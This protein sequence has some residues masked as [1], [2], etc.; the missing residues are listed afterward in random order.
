MLTI[1]WTT[2]EPNQDCSQVQTTY[3][4]SLAHARAILVKLHQ[5][6]I[7]HAWCLDNG[8]YQFGYIRDTETSETIQG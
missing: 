6:G 2:L 8:K 7:D 3:P 1:H 5:L 4:R